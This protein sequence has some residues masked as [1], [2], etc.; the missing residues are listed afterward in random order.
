MIDVSIIIVSWNV[1]EFLFACLESLQRSQVE[2]VP[3]NQNIQHLSSRTTIEI[4]V[5]DSASSDNTLEML[6]A[7]PDIRVLSQLTNLGFAKCNNIGLKFA[8]GRYLFLLN[9]DAEIVNDAIQVMVDYLDK[10]HSV[11]VLGPFL[12][13]ANG[14]LQIM[15]RIFPNL[16]VILFETPSLE[17]YMS[18]KFL[19]Y[20]CVVNP[21]ENAQIA[22]DWVLGA[23]MMARRE[24]Y[25]Q[26]GLLDEKYP[27]YA[28]EIDWC[29]R[30]KEHQWKV[31]CLGT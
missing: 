23:A 3:P 9:P 25:D 30:A 8:R 20:E 5:V 26:I 17:P 2:I 11:G 29:F 13:N 10:H 28:E 24:V 7:F 14:S 19:E 18:K 27:M 16:T 6:K 22:V 12:T 31:I 1:S 15:P 21:P 4:I